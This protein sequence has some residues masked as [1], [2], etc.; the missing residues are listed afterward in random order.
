M[1]VGPVTG[2]IR[3]LRKDAWLQEAGELADQE[4]LRRFVLAKDELAFEMMVR[5]HG[6][7]VLSVCRH[8]VHDGH[9]AEDAFQATFLVLVRKAGSIRKP[10]QLSSWLY[11][12]AYRVATHARAQTERRRRKET[13]GLEMEPASPPLQD[14]VVDVQPVL[15]Q[16]LERLPQKYRLPMVLCYLQ[17]KTNEEAANTLACPIGTV[18]GRLARAREMLR[19]R[20]TRRGVTLSA[21]MLS[22]VCASSEASAALP[23]RLIETTVASAVRLAA[24]EALTAGFV[25]VEIA[26]LTK[27]ALH[28]MWLT[29][30]GVV[31]TVLLGVSVA[32]GSAGLWALGSEPN[33]GSAVFPVVNVRDDKADE[34]ALHLTIQGRMKKIVLAMHNYQDENGRFPA[35]YEVSK[36]GKPTVSW[37]VLI[38]PYLDEKDLYK[39]FKLDEPWDSDHNKKLLSKMPEVYAPA[40]PDPKEANVTFIQV[41]TGPDTLF[42]GV[43]GSRIADI[44][45]GTSNTILIVEAGEAV[46][47]TKP[48]DIACPAD[49]PLPKV[50]KEFQLGFH[51]GFADGSI[52]FLRKDIKEQT[53]RAL[54]TP[55]GG[56]V[57]S[58]LPE[59]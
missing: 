38:L 22:A 33:A 27:G 12:V 35:A 25:S 34:E 53:L 29:K 19:K 57:V 55:S 42:R 40:R 6:P 49:K 3:N 2:L 18:K 28:H 47:W 30:G 43:P 14:R 59:L 16:E 5:R 48:V 32:A 45:D 7:M 9:T 11:G 50:G 1:T 21:G 13:Q 17:G 4:L 24:G 37:R 20:L 41:F 23:A 10:G 46:P 39:Q 56:E 26:S 31:G 54:I 8:L 15:Y 51:A 52:H 44:T 58:D 36:N